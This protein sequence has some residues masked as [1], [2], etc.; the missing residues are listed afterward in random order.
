[1]MAKILISAV[2]SF[3]QS[4]LQSAAT[5]FRGG[6]PL[7]IATAFLPVWGALPIAHA[8]SALHAEPRVHPQSPSTEDDAIP[9]DPEDPRLLRA[10]E[11]AR[12]GLKTFLKHLASPAPD[13]ASFA[14]KAAFVEGSIVEA[15]WVSDVTYASGVFTGRLSNDPQN[16][17]RL[18]YGDLVKIKETEILDW[19]IVKGRKLIGGFTIRAMREMLDAKGRA[20]FD[21]SLG[22]EL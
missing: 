1:M 6:L 14:V 13:M 3:F 9:V 15:I 17:R 19:M 22:L 16:L 5:A 21:E 8:D 4:P 10:T 7:L 12:K 2:P 11:E 18:H 20:A